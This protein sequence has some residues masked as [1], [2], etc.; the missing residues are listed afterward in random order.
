MCVVSSG[1]VHCILESD[2]IEGDQL[3]YITLTYSISLLYFV[4]A[5]SLS[6]TFIPFLNSLY[7]HEL[8]KEEIYLYLYP[9]CS[10]YSSTVETDCKLNIV[11]DIFT[12]SF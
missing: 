3:L 8:T 9:P 1:P 7:D 5:Y 6:H 4:W 10:M 11:F 2:P 12:W